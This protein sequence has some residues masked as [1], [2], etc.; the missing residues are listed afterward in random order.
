MEILTLSKAKPKIGRL[1]DRALR[2]EAV[3]IRKGDRMVQL[4][5][6][7]IPEPIPERP[8]GFFR[9]RPS[10]YEVANHASSS[11]APVR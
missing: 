7:V 1:I 4:T 8:I 9:R 6:F 5:E 3:V 10:D 11:V 2:G